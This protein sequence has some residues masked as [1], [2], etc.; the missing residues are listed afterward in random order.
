MFFNGLFG[1]AGK[2]VHIGK[3]GDHFK[4]LKR[5]PFRIMIHLIRAAKNV[6]GKND[7]NS[8]VRS[9]A[10]GV[11]DALFGGIVVFTEKRDEEPFG[12]QLSAKPVFY[13]IEIH[14][15]QFFTVCLVVFFK[16]I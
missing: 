9:V 4:I 10:G 16:D 5:D 11:Q 13:G 3:M 15:R 6:L 1:I 7:G 2:V 8:I 14:A 12:Y